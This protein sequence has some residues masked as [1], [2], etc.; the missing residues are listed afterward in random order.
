MGMRVLLE[1]REEKEDLVRTLQ[2]AT[3]NAPQR[4]NAREVVA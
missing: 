3:A 4:L 2:T 1:R